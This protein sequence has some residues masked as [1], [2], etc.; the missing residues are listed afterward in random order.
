MSVNLNLP[1]L[2]QQLPLLEHMSSAQLMQ[3]E[4][5]QAVAQ[6]VAREAGLKD[7][8]QV[9]QTEPQ[10][11]SQAVGEESGQGQGGGGSQRK[12]EEEPEEEGREASSDNPWAGNIVNMNI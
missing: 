10:E 5:A 11:G 9:Q 4:A 7:R 3:L 1:V 6:E 8:E 12:Y 2:F